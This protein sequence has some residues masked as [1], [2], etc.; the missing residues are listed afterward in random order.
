MTT[1]C[2]IPLAII[3]L[4]YLAVWMA[5]RAVSTSQ[6]LSVQWKSDYSAQSLS[7]HL[8][9]NH[10]LPCSRRSQ[11]P[12]RKLREKCL[13]W[14][15]WWLWHTASAGDRTPPLPVL[16]QLTRDTPSILWLLPCL[17]TLPRAPPFTTQLSMSSWTDRWAQLSHSSLHFNVLS[18]HKCA[19][20][21]SA[22]PCL[23]YAALW[24]RG[25]WWLWSI[26]IKDRG[27]LRGSCINL[28]VLSVVNKVRNVMVCTVRI[29]CLFILFFF[30]KYSFLA[31]GKSI[32]KCKKLSDFWLV[33]FGV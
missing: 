11:N 14:W 30:S 19:F 7:L 8:S 12:P 28:H 4:C 16:L 26:H 5:I 27:F 25:G 18:F 22:V 23:H 6:L 15:L 13:G 31:N 33:F 3:I 24:Q 32:K 1:C 21:S 2:L 29:N 17:H 20:C 10:R 9:A